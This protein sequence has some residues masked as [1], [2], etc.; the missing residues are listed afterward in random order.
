[1]E[2]QWQQNQH[3]ITEK[4]FV[5]TIN[6]LCGLQKPGNEGHFSNNTR[7]VDESYEDAPEDDD[8]SENEDESK[9]DCGDL[10]QINDAKPTNPFRRKSIS[11]CRHKLQGR[12]G[13]RSRSWKQSPANQQLTIEDLKEEDADN[14]WAQLRKMEKFLE[15]ERLELL[16]QGAPDSDDEDWD[17]PQWPDEREDCLDEEEDDSLENEDLTFITSVLES[18]SKPKSR[19]TKLNGSCYATL[20]PEGVPT[21]AE[22]KQ[23]TPRRFNQKFNQNSMSESSAT[24]K[25]N[26]FPTIKEEGADKED[27]QSEIDP[28]NG[29]FETQSEI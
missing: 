2:Q 6:F 3:E 24:E 10:D 9:S 28:E 20:T 13:Y 27:T 29:E 4:E 8:D 19:A 21:Q 5:H 25:F 16:R 22:A 11:L 14:E 12:T 7:R 18:F 26:C 23:M 15:Q 1:V 17:E